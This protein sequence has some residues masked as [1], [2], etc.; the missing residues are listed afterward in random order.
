MCVHRCVLLFSNV[1]AS[2]DFRTQIQYEEGKEALSCVSGVY[3]KRSIGLVSNDG[4]H[5]SCFFF[6]PLFSHTYMA[7]FRSIKSMNSTPLEL[8]LSFLILLALLPLPH[9]PPLFFSWCP[10]TRL[11]AYFRPRSPNKP[12]CAT[13]CAS[14]PF[15]TIV[16]SFV[17]IRRSSSFSVFFGSLSR[18]PKSGDPLFFFVVILLRPVAGFI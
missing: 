5:S 8:I 12:R 9:Q 18:A 4:C 17:R 1:R 11:P 10:V 14:P 6:F 13:V 2:H 3:H 7:P 16:T 15:V